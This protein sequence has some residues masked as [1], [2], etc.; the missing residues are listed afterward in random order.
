M[1]VI[2]PGKGRAIIE[3]DGATLR[4]TI[5]A[6]LKLLPVLY[7]VFTSVA[8]LVIAMVF[9]RVIINHGLSMA[10]FAFWAGFAVFAVGAAYSVITVMWSFAG[11]ETI[12]L[13]DTVLKRRKQI[14]F[15]SRRREYRVADI[16]DM[17]V[18]A[19]SPV[20]QFLSARLA[21]WSYHEGAIA[22]DYGRSTQEIGPGLDEAD[23]KYVVGE[24]CKRV[25]S[26][27]APRSATR[28][29]S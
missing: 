2:E 8:M 20:K 23:A 12:E 28:E 13:D 16:S 22:F 29:A 24:M 10:M 27:G 21:G 25:K 6:Q 18:A 5:P 17:R 4:I 11:R 14:P 15:L 9:L 19:D 3:N 1:A 26:L 7:L